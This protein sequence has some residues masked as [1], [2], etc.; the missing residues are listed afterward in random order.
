MIIQVLKSTANKFTIDLWRK[1]TGEFSWFENWNCSVL[2]LKN[3]AFSY[4]Y[5]VHFMWMP[6]IAFIDDK[7][8]FDES[9]L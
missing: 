5:Y 3:C 9:R 7:Y 1:V 4:F 6:H 2:W 8:L